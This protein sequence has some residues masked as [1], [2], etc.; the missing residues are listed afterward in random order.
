M[1]HPEIPKKYKLALF[2]LSLYPKA[3]I[4]TFYG[5]EINN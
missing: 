5:K 1:K 4:S 3:S 2:S